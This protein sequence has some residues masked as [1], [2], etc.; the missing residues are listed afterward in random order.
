MEGDCPDY[1]VARRPNARSRQRLR[2]LLLA[3]VH[4][5]AP[6]LSPPCQSRK[7]RWLPEPGVLSPPLTEASPNAP[8]LHL[9]LAA[10]TPPPPP[11]S[12]PPPPQVGSL[13]LQIQAWEEVHTSRWIIQ[14]IR[15]GYHLPWD[16]PKA[17]LTSSPPIFQP[18]TLAALDQDE[19]PLLSK[20]VTEEVLS[21]SSR[22]FYGWVFVVPKSSEGW[23]PVGT[24]Q[25]STSSCRPSL[26]EG[27][28]LLLGTVSTEG[29][30]VTST[31]LLDIYFHILIHPRNRCGSV[32]CGGAG[33]SSFEPSLLVWPLLPGFLTR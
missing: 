5:E 13:S 6:G 30:W 16:S 23:R 14:V 19:A 21:I 27:D 26:P 18:Q 8:L 20:G 31:G 32:L 1:R 12:P 2:L 28:S 11:H 17:P 24:C 33:F 29:H 22:G 3:A 25:L 7:S 10:P 4:L 15:S 9:P